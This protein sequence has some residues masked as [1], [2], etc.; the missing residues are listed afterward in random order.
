VFVIGDAAFLI[1]WKTNKQVP[2]VSQ[3]ALQMGR[4]VARVIQ[5]D[6]SSNDPAQR[7]KLRA[8]G[9]HYKDFGSMAT[10]GKSRAVVEMG[11]LRFGGFLAW[12]AWLALHITVLIGFRNRAS[13]LLSWIY[14][15]FFYGRGSRLI[16]NFSSEQMAELSADTMKGAGGTA[17]S[18][19]SGGTAAPTSA[20]AI[21]LPGADA[22]REA[23]PRPGSP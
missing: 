1:D 14:S 21:A 11:R 17:P 8:E 12:C 13:V 18:A 3:G 7:G 19:E 2:G 23:P 9:F 15:Y 5:Q 10:I 22:P 16:T 20:P 6:I 4:Y